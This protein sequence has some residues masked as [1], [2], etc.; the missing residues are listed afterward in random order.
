MTTRRLRNIVANEKG[1]AIIELALVAPVF[2]LMAIGVVDMSNAF[3]R[4]L[5]LEQG[6]QRAI[7]K[8]MQTTELDTV[9]ETL[10]REARCQVNGTNQDGT[11]K[12]TPIAESDV[13]VSRRRECVSA[14]GAITNSKTYTTSDDFDADATLCGTDRE[15]GY[16]QVALTDKYTPMFPIHFYSYNGGDGTYH[17]SATAGMRTQ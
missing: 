5:A 13:T 7:E 10:T 12:E 11:C 16:I 3:S 9:D 8:I 4:K 17:L 2:A 15:T 1:A 6:A 14:S